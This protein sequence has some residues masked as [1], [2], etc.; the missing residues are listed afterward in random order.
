MV[1]GAVVSSHAAALKAELGD[2]VKRQMRRLEI[3]TSAR[4]L[5]ALGIAPGDIVNVVAAVDQPAS[6]D[7]AE[8]DRVIAR[9]AT[10]FAVEDLSGDRKLISIMASEADAEAVASAAG[11]GTLRLVLVAP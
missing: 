2:E 11:S 5:A 4:V 8:V 1:F 6:E 9:S 10:V 7:G 3:E